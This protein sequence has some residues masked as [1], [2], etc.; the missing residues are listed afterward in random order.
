MK[1]IV[2]GASGYLGKEL[3]KSLIA[4]DCDVY[5]VSRTAL[6]L[7]K[8]KSLSLDVNNIEHLLN[9]KDIVDFCKTG[10][11]IFYNLVWK[12]VNKLKDGSI[13]DQFKNV[14]LSTNCLKVA[15]KLNCQ[16]YINVSSQDEAIYKNY[17]NQNIWKKE[18]Y[19]E[20]DLAY[21][22]AKLATKNMCLIEAYLNKI[23]F[24][25]TRFSVILDQNLS[26]TSFITNNIKKILSKQEYSIPSNNGPIEI[27]SLID[28][29]EAYYYIGLY[30]KN[31]ADYYIGQGN[32]T[33]LS[34]FFK[35][36]KNIFEN[37]PLDNKQNIFDPQILSIFDNKSFIEDTSFKFKYKLTSIIEDIIKCNRQ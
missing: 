32:V 8:V 37:T 18:A 7:N 4:H 6:N 11:V 1:A 34:Y 5:A 22:A 36:V 23:D 31:K 27:N 29:A 19:S 24:I 14:Q 2:L 25:N 15:S 33:N 17:L 20:Y 28:V 10:D 35:N 9:N 16:K 3:C 12:G 30:G 13:E 21:S 26:S